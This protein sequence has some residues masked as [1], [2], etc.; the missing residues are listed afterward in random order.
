MESTKLNAVKVKSGYKLLVEF[1]NKVCKEY[2]VRERLN[3]PLFS[4]LKDPQI[5]NLVR[6]SDD[7]YSVTWEDE[8][9]ISEHELWFYGED[10][11]TQVEVFPK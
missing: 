10:I 5:F 3:S 4:K 8:I 6:I 2:D 1:E 9:D 11:D 7:G